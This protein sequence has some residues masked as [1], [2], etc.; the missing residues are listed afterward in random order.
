MPGIEEIKNGLKKGF[1]DAVVSVEEQNPTRMFVDI[2]SAKVRDVSNAIVAMGGRYLVSVGYDNIAR[3]GTL[4]MIHT[5]GFD[6]D[7]IY[8]ALRTSVPESQPEMDSITPDIP[9]AGWSEREYMDLLGM[10]FS[11]HP[12]PKRLVLADDW[13]EGVHTLRKDIPW[14]LMPPAA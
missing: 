3:D 5:F 6:R 13:P 7:G 1:K 2:K 12:K 10:R 11:G 4:G 9:N 8:L 14:N